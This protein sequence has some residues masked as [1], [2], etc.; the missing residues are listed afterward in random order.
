MNLLKIITERNAF[1]REYGTWLIVFFN[2]IL[3]PLLWQKFTISILMFGLSILF[4]LMFRF[5]LLDLFSINIQFAKKSKV[6]KSLIYLLI[7]ITFFCILIINSLLDLELAL[8]V[9]I[10][11]ISMLVL[12]IAT[13]RR[14]GKRQS[15]VAQ[16]VLVSFISFLGALN[17]ILLIGYF[18]KIF[19]TIFLT[20]SFFYSNSVLFVRSKT[21]GS[22][23]D[24]YALLFSVLSICFFAILITL[25]IYN[26]ETIIIFIPTFVKTLDNVILANFKVPLRRIGINE[27]IHCILFVGLFWLLKNHF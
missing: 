11:G 12:N 4:F 14:K 24:I 13:R 22:P 3:V 1:S 9:S 6:I 2:F 19:F 17:Y 20:S 16:I 26:I 15:I 27:T 18:D 23:F 5:E 25:K 8:L 7:S 21:L 10:C